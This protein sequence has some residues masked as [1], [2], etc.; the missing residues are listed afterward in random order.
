M[1]EIAAKHAGQASETDE[2]AG[3]DHAAPSAAKRAA[4]ARAADAATRRLAGDA[5]SD[6]RGDLEARFK[7][8]GAAIDGAHFRA[9]M[10]AV[11]GRFGADAALEALRATLSRYA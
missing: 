3:A 8:A 7:Q 5:A 9:A 2:V 1:G 4:D 6:A 11:A 10:A